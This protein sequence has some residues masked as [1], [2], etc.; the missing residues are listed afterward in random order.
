MNGNLPFSFYRNKN[1]IPSP[2]VFSFLPLPR[3]KWISPLL[4]IHFDHEERRPE[5]PQ[6]GAV[7]SWRKSARSCNVRAKNPF[8]GVEAWELRRGQMEP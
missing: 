3:R 2:K 4:L 8:V 7:K 5:K 6:S 1:P